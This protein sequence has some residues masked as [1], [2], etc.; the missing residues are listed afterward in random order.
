MRPEAVIL[1]LSSP[2]AHA[3][4]RDG[5]S[6]IAAV[7]QSRLTPAALKGALA[8]LALEDPPMHNLSAISSW[9]DVVTHTKAFSWTEPLHFTNVQDASPACLINGN[10][11]G[12]GNCTFDYS[13]DCVDR[14]GKNLGFCNAGAIANFSSQLRAG[15]KAGRTDNQTRQALKFVVHFVGDIMQPL[16]CGM[17]A[18]HGGVFINVV[19][20]VKGQGSDWN[21]HNVWDFGLIVNAEGVEGN[22][23]PLVADIGTQLQSGPW[24]A[25]APTWADNSD[26]KAWVQ[27]SLNTATRFAYD[28]ANGT[29]IRRTH[30]RQDHVVLGSALEKYMARGGVIEEQMA[31]AGVRLAAL[32]NT[33]WEA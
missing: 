12:Y 10:K 5:H 14:D 33:V 17:L 9:A 28:F 1:L 20:P 22:Y 18:D 7:A 3:W 30:G 2:L 23:A 31:R 4:G 25:E 11:G 21:L 24:K 32:L 6:I 16:H 19:Y 27:E 8:L 13:R 26:P 29:A 15:V